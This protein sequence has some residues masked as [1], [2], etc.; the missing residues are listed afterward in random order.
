M[1]NRTKRKKDSDGLRSPA[2]ILCHQI[3]NR[4]GKSAGLLAHGSPALDRLPV[5]IH[6]GSGWRIPDRAPHHLQLRDSHGVTPCSGMLKSRVVYHGQGK[7]QHGRRRKKR[8]AVVQPRQLFW[9][10]AGARFQ[11]NPSFFLFLL[12]PIVEGW[13]RMGGRRKMERSPAT[14]NGQRTVFLCRYCHDF[15]GARVRQTEEFLRVINERYAD[16]GVQ[17]AMKPF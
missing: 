12:T 11:K 10:S 1:P 9:S 15:V 13:E 4:F 3:P 6:R 14:A 17:P 5:A 8:R 7:C 2:E 16:R